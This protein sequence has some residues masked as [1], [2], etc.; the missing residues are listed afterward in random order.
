MHTHIRDAT[1]ADADFVA[2]VMQTA[3]RS[4]RPLSFWDLGFPG[5]DAQRLEYLSA[6]AKAEPVTMA[7]Y[8]GFIVA[9]RDGRAVGGLSAYDSALKGID[10]F[11]AALTGVL[12]AAGWSAEHQQLFSER[13][14]PVGTCLSESPAGV[15]IVEWVAVRPEARGQGVAHDLLV[16]ILERGRAA[17]YTRAQISYLIGNTPAERAYHAVGFEA[18]DDK[19]HPEFEKVF[20]SPGICRMQCEL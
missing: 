19:R 2:W 3:A 15:W 1:V 10:V 9:E 18:V 12:V 7:H 5:P 14:A 20:G 4:H 16:E 11:F 17:G 13:I 6:V 8:G